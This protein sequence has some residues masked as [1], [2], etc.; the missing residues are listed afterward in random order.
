MHAPA[1]GVRRFL[2]CL[3]AVAACCWVGGCAAIFGPGEDMPP[4][5]DECVERIADAERSRERTSRNDALLHYM[6]LG[7]YQQVCREFARSAQS[8]EVAKRI[9]DDLYTKSISAEAVALLGND[10]MRPYPGENF[11]RAMLRILNALNFA[12][13]GRMESALVE[14]RQVDFFLRELD[15]AEG[16]GNTYSEDAFGRYLTGMLHEEAGDIDSA[17]ISYSLAVEAYLKT[18]DVYGV[19]VPA[20]L[21]EALL[22]VARRHSPDAVA[23]ASALGARRARAL[24]QGAGEVVVVHQVGRVPDKVEEIFNVSWG[25]GWAYASRYD[26]NQ[27]DLEYR[28]AQDIALTIAANETFRVAF[29]LFVDRRYEITDIGLAAPDHLGLSR[30]V[31]VANVGAV[32]KKDLQDRI[33]RIRARTIARAAVYFAAQKYAEREMLEQ[34]KEDAAN[35]IAIAGMLRSLVLEHADRRQWDSLPDRIH[36]KSIILPA[37]RHAIRLDY[38]SSQGVVR[39]EVLPDVR[40]R[41]GRRTFVVVRSAR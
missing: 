11:E 40:V 24:P 9:G 18:A 29:P 16:G 10:A 3:P 26:T 37:G 8:F 33:H 41:P 2:Q 19:G 35:A 14:A 31:L 23:E 32:A 12:A 27:N 25:H 20:P 7:T 22:A 30:T 13:E 17:R 39:T 4:T 38:L 21:L 5:R 28:R 34:E 1:N 6:R 15:Q 36:L